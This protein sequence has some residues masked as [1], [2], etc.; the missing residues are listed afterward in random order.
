MTSLR[1]IFWKVLSQF[2]KQKGVFEGSTRICLQGTL[3]GS[4]QGFDVLRGFGFW[5][6]GGSR[7][8]GFRLKGF[9]S[10]VKGV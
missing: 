2:Y 10:R 3:K 8:Q 7:F 6:S 4:Y 9:G 1:E 5:A